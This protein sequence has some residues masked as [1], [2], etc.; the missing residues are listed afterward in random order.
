MGT[1]E[2]LEANCGGCGKRLWLRRGGELT[3][4][5]RI[6]RLGDDMQFTAKCPKCGESVPVPFL[7]LR[8]RGA[9]R[10]VMVDSARDP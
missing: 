9:R 7:G 1:P 2:D 3:L 5:T 8:G 6:L 10:L 4:A